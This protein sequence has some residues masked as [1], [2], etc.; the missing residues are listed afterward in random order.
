MGAFQTRLAIASRS[1]NGGRSCQLLSVH[2]GQKLESFFLAMSFDQRRCCFGGGMS[3]EAV[4]SF[5]R[6]INCRRVLVIGRMGPYFLEA[7]AMICPLGNDADT[8]EL[9]LAC[10]LECDRSAIIRTLIDLAVCAALPLYR[11]LIVQREL[12]P[13]DMLSMLRE[14]STGN[15]GASDITIRL[16]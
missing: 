13:P 15:A 12:L 16:R 7:V 2:D 10:P 4:I 5:C 8:A 6:A 11:K 1:V 9:S 14:V 3:D